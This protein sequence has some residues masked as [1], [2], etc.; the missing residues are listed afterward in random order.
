MI[1]HWLNDS[2]HRRNI[3]KAT[4]PQV[5]DHSSIML[6]FYP[7]TWQSTSQV[8][9]RSTRL[10]LSPH[11]V[12]LGWPHPA[13]AKTKL[14]RFRPPYRSW[15]MWIARDVEHQAISTVIGRKSK[16]FWCQLRNGRRLLWT[17]FPSKK[18]IW[19][20]IC[21][22]WFRTFVRRKLCAVWVSW[23]KNCLKRLHKL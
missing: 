1:P 20:I 13:T 2:M 14:T 22:F 19:T 5:L 17:D 18:K 16:G 3:S 12:S 8:Q 7:P 4:Q 9:L 10:M 23:T 21:S 6:S 15:A 11:R